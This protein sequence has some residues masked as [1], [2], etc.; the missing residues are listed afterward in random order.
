M[1]FSASRLVSTTMVVRASQQDWVAAAR[2]Y[3]TWLSWPTWA[4]SFTNFLMVR[5]SSKYPQRNSCR[6]GL[7]RSNTGVSIHNLR[8]LLANWS[9]QQI[10]KIA[11]RFCQSRSLASNS[12]HIRRQWRQL[13]MKLGILNIRTQRPLRGC[14]QC[15]AVTSTPNKWIRYQ[16][17]TML[18]FL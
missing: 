11:Q 7:L 17:L 16:T 1:T 4:F 8:L 5:L 9:P 14:L 2:S 18:R 3:F 13:L 15:A 6:L 10:L 12:M